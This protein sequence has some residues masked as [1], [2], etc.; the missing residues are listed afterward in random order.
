MEIKC[1]RVEADEGDRRL[2]LFSFQKKSLSRSFY[3]SYVGGHV[4]VDGAK[5]SKTGY[6][7][8][9]GQ[10]VKLCIPPPKVFNL[11]RKIFPWKSSTKIAICWLLINPKVW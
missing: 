4:Y 3:R 10:N 1:F 11:S 5:Q 7:V 9:E 8:K 2:D 6:R